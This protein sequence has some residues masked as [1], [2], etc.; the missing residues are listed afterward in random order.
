MSM[1]LFG[2]APSM[3]AG[4]SLLLL[5]GGVVSH[6][7]AAPAPA[8]D[9]ASP[10][11]RLAPLAPVAPTAAA[12]AAG[13]RPPVSTAPAPAAADGGGAAV[14][15]VIVIDRNFIMQRSAA[16]KDMLNQTQS[17]SKTSEAQFKKE[18]EALSTEAQQLS[19]QLAILAADVRAQ[20]EKDFLAKQQAFQ[21][22]VQTR[23]AEIQAGFNKAAR[24]LETALEP[25]LQNI[26]RERGANMVL[27][28]Q[29][30]IIAAGDIDVTPVAVQ[31]L[32]KVLPR[33]K[34]ELTSVAA[35]TVPVA[36]AA[37]PA[38]A[39]AAAPSGIPAALA[40]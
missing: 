19:Q 30:V 25:I 4:F 21:T 34:V 39:P 10:F 26:M 23:Q 40:K 27:D 24:Q 32:D 36:P 35:N 8:A 29:A 1:K 2:R 9:A 31:R 16:G 3:V 14:P 11:G 7:V 37:L 38:P 22:R 33:V 13:A 5:I 18:E 20:K 12:P 28:R 6:S 17:L 15:R